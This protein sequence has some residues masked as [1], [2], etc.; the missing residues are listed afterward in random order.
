MEGWREAKIAKK[1]DKE[2]GEELPVPVD[3]KGKPCRSTQ[4]VTSIRSTSLASVS[5]GFRS[6]RCSRSRMLASPRC[7]ASPPQLAMTTS[8]KCCSKP[9]SISTRPIGSVEHGAHPCCET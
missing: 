7:C 4:S 1:Y 5:A 6:R 2:S 9:A 3:K 8:L